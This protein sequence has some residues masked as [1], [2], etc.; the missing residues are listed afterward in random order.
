MTRDELKT[1]L[2]E[3]LARADNDMAENVAA[4]M[5]KRFTPDALSMWT[6][7][8]VL[9]HIAECMAPPPED[10]DEDEEAE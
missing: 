6:P 7:P 5:W 10:T 4:R 9:E 2:T 1:Y 8:G 3:M